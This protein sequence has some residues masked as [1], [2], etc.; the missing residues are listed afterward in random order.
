MERYRSAHLESDNSLKQSELLHIGFVCC[1]LHCRMFAV[2]DDNKL[3]VVSESQ[4]MA[5]QLQFFSRPTTHVHNSP[6]RDCV[7][8]AMMTMTL[9]QL[10]IPKPQVLR[11]RFVVEV[12]TVKAALHA[13]GDDNL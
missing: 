2:V 13:A 1:N 12:T 4:S 7:Q 5:M 9:A 10:V 3:V 6:L 8:C 11:S